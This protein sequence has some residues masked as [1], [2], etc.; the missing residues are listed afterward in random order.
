MDLKTSDGRGEPLKADWVFASFKPGQ[1]ATPSDLAGANV[2]W[3]AVS[4][5]GTV[6]S[7]QRESGAFSWGQEDLDAADH[8]F[9]CKVALP[10]SKRISLCF[11]GLATVAKVFWN[12][13]L[14]L[15]SDNM[16]LQHD[17][18]LSHLPRRGTLSICFQALTT[19]L[20]T[21]R[22]RPRWRTRL[23]EQQ[24]LRWLRTSLMGR[25]PG[26]SPTA[27]P[28]GPFR[29]VMVRTS[30]DIIVQENH[31][32]A[33]LA[34][35]NG[36]VAIRLKLRL[37]AGQSIGKSV[38]HVGNASAS[39][40]AEPCTE[41]LVM[42][43]GEVF[44]PDAEPW[45]PHTHGEP[46]LYPVWVDLQVAD[47]CVR[48]TLASV[49]FRHLHIHQLDGA[50]Q[51]QI[52]GTPVFCRGACWTPADVLTLHAD[53]ATLRQTLLLAKAAGMNMVRIGGTMVYESD[54][55]YRLC[56][57]LGML[58]WQ[59]FMFANMDYPVGDDNFSASIAIE[60]QQFLQRV[61]ARP[62]LTVL[63][64]GS[65][66]EQQ[67]A[68]LGLP[69]EHWRNAFFGV[70]LP[71]ICAEICPQV[72]YLASSPS[73]GVM[74]F[75]VD[76]SVSHYYGVGAYLRPLEDARRAGVRF[77]SECLGFSNIPE[78]AT[79]E[80]LLGNGQQPFHH[81]IWKQRVPRDSGAGWD[82]EDVRDHYLATLFKVDPMQLRYADM[83]RYLYM[84]RVVT[85][86][87]MAR[88][89]AEWR[90]EA[91]PCQG[92]LIWFLRDLWPGA[93]W[94]VID[95]H[96]VPKAAYFALKRVMQAQA[97]V[98]SDE[99]LNGLVLHVFNDQALP[100]DGEINLRLVR[101]GEV[102]VAE[103]V[104]AVH[105]PAHGSL[106]LRADA[107]FQHFVDTSYAYRFGPPGHHAAVAT[108]STGPEAGVTSQAFHFPVGYDT[109]LVTDLGL[110]A[111]F[112]QVANGI[113]RVALATRHLAQF[114]RLD[115]PGCL[116][117]DNYFHLA[118]GV[119]RQV[120]LQGAFK[121]GVPKGTVVALNGLNPVKISLPT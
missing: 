6:A 31:L 98:I 8:W 73:G 93:G 33:A 47:T 64:G 3:S 14:I 119:T 37:P 66:I 19:A 36:H 72:P 59:D 114:V 30:K 15:S 74:P 68:M 117:A 116:P 71:A 11:E 27:A 60:A 48:L 78:E 101:H 42:L 89:I 91:S 58:V 34:A 103:A 20:A 105:V 112:E 39:L 69:P 22:P 17:V 82:F 16:F 24:Q 57:E 2:A 10:D 62:C 54:L 115:V 97:V 13:A 12:D 77:T 40:I 110:T 76:Q 9:Q 109:S 84:S 45:W 79:V 41:E 25:I 51:V 107:M 80:S 52:N 94:G 26:W 118:P 113:W 28:V 49:G 29:P 75:Q 99:G 21:R 87:V 61:Q 111:Q 104:Q 4:V 100:F 55:F 90:R 106:E 108:L 95:A 92:A 83:A 81:P 96:G 70:T 88:T 35:G 32:R 1:V 63:C 65:E 56:D 85:G 5:P 53:E 7:A 67:A 102:Q 18:D 44:V 86:E 120:E 43:T 23:V 46:S 50:F 38:L 121:G